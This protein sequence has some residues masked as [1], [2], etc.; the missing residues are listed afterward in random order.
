Y[1]LITD[2]EDLVLRSTVEYAHSRG[3]KAVHLPM[4]TRT[5]TCPTGLGSDSEPV[6]VTVGG[7]D[8][9]LPDSQQFLLEY[10]CRLAP[11]GCYSLTTSFRGE[12]PDA[13]HLNQY[14]HSEAEI[15]GGL[16]ELI[17]Y[18]EGYV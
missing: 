18:V 8:T 7:V 5:V 15:P 9:Y 16:E 14:M 13:T 10:G 6:P 17:D 3:L 2:L 4:T 1:G 11:S 12:R